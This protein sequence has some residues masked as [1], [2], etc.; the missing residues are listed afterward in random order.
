[1]LGKSLSAFQ[2]ELQRQTE[3]SQKVT[4]VLNSVAGAF[5][6][7]QAQPTPVSGGAAQ[8]AVTAA[9]ADADPGERAEVDDALERVF[10]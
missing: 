9:A 6:V 5:S 2:H 10:K 1:V 4:A 3:T 7:N 8:P